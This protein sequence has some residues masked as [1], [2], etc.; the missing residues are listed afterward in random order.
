MVVSCSTFVA[1][2]VAFIANLGSFILL[3]RTV[4]LRRDSVLPEVVLFRF[5]DLILSL[6]RARR[7]GVLRGGH[8]VLSS[9]IDLSLEITRILCA[10]LAA[11]GAD[12]L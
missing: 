7:A 5:T 9:V 10:H 1:V 11:P 12:H 2:V 3:A 4:G 8:C 6:T